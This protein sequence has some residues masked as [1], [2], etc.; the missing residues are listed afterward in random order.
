MKIV[1]INSRRLFGFIRPRAKLESEGLTFLAKV[2]LTFIVPAVAFSWT[3]DSK[4]LL[5][6]LTAEQVIAGVCG[7]L[8]YK[9]PARP[10]LSCVPVH[11]NPNVPA[12][13]IRKAA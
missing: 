1:N 13:Q 8:L 9:L 7:W 6:C 5:L 3:M 4:V 10:P 2:A 12:R 11:L